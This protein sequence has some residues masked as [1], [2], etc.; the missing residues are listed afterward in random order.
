MPTTVE[1][2]GH[3]LD[4]DG[5]GADLG[6]VADRDRP[7]QLGAGAD[8][9]VVAEGRMALAALEAGAAQ[10]DP[11]VEGDAVADL[12]GLADHDAGRRGR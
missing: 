9:D 1:S 2:G 10:G 12:G 3:V 4:D 5:V 6:A 8:G 7:E 11:L